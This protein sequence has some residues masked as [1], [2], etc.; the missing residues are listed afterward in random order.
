MEISIRRVRVDDARVLSALARQTFFDTF[1]GTCSEEDMALFLEQHYNEAQLAREISDT[2]TFC[3]FAEM[4][5]M[6]VAYILFKEDYENFPTEKKWKAL[7]LKRIYVQK[8]FHGNGIAQLLMN[9]ILSFAA[10]HTYELLWLGVWEHN[11]KAQ[12]FYEKYGFVNSG[13][14]HDFP[15]GNTPQTDVWLWKFL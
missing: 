11:L 12:R 13:F 3:F 1:T 6:P 2:E 8:E 15:I 9:H 10:A 14:T 5:G 7:E 4:N